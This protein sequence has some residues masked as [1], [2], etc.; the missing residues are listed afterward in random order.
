METY[1]RMRGSR[2]LGG[3]GVIQKEQPERASLRRAVL[4][5]GLGSDFVHLTPKLKA[6]N[7]KVS[8]GGYSEAKRSAQ[9]RK[10]LKK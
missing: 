2:V 1:D 5:T 4:D 7:A 6:M 10:P 9:Q 8:K 3:R